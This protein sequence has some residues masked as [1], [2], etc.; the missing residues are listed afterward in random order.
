[1]SIGIIL[2]IVLGVLKFPTEVSAFIRLIS[3]TPDEKRQEITA[4]IQKQ[5]DAF[6]NTGRPS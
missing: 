5:L 2:E 4:D 3:K 1:M 6:E